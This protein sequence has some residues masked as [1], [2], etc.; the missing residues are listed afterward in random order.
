MLLIAF[1]KEKILYSFVL[2]TFYTL[3]P[4]FH[5]LRKIKDFYALLLT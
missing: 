3:E 5:L 2:S 1:F 4:R